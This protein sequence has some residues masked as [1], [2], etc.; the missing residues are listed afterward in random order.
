MW[1]LAVGDKHTSE[2]F[3]SKVLWKEKKYKK[4]DLADGRC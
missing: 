4:D 3:V 2:V 1:L